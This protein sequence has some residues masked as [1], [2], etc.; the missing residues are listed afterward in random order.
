MTFTIRNTYTNPHFPQK[1]TKLAN[2]SRGR[3][4][5]IFVFASK[6]ATTIVSCSLMQSFSPAD[7]SLSQPRPTNP[8]VSIRSPLDQMSS[9]DIPS[10]T[11]PSKSKKILRIVI[12]LGRGL[13]PPVH[14]VRRIGRDDK[15]RFEGPSEPGTFNMT[16]AA[17]EK[18]QRVL[19]YGQNAVKDRRH[20]G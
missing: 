7:R 13:A 6:L 12:P 19:A 20:G 18:L 11:H 4:N 17:S 3:P 8:T 10:A 15:N 2:T 9:D 14:I 1:S 5:T 16:K